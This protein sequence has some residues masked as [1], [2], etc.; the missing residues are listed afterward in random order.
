[1]IDVRDDGEVADMGQRRGHARRT[2]RRKRRCQQGLKETKD[3]DVRRETFSFVALAAQ[4][5]GKFSSMAHPVP[6]AS[7]RAKGREDRTR[8]RRFARA[9]RQQIRRVKEPDA[10]G[11][12]GGIM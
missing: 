5:S 8:P 3:T 2:S 4:S 7:D 9:A 10:R 6:V 1:M 12:H 11:W